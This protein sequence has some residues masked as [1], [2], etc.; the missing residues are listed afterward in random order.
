MGAYYSPLSYFRGGKSCRRQ[1]K[2][3]GFYPS[4]MSGVVR[5]GALLVPLAIRQSYK[6]C[7]RNSK[8]KKSKKTKKTQKTQKTQRR[9]SRKNR[10]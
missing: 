7:T 9:Q 8:T 6:L 4:I 2:N 5:N 3:G 1:S 10:K